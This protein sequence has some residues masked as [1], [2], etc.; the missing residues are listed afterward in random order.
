[1][2]RPQLAT[3]EQ[4]FDALERRIDDAG[5]FDLDLVRYTEV[6][7]QQLDAAKA[8]FPFMQSVTR[9]EYSIYRSTKDYLERRAT[10]DVYQMDDGSPA[11][12]SKDFWAA[13]YDYDP[14]A[15]A[16]PH[17]RKLIDLLKKGRLGNV[18]IDGH[19][20]EDNLRLTV[21]SQGLSRTKP[22]PVITPEEDNRLRPFYS[23][24][25]VMQEDAFGEWRKTG[26]VLVMDMDDR[27][28]RHRHP[29]LVLASQWPAE[30]C[31]D[32]EDDSGFHYV[33]E[34]V[35]RNAEAAAGVFPGDRNRTPI[36]SIQPHLPEGA[37]RSDLPVLKQLGED[38]NFAPYRY[39][40]AYPVKDKG[41][42]PD[43]AFVMDWYWDPVNEK[44]I[45]YYQDGTIYMCY[46]PSKKEYSYPC[47]ASLAASFIG[48]QSIFGEI[49]GVK[50]APEQVEPR[51][52]PLSERQGLP[53]GS[54]TSV[55]VLRRTMESSTAGF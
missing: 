52:I 17:S 46:D 35:Y 23:L 55:P 41:K 48:Q 45:C 43:I 30:D 37:S 20:S 1:M 24:G 39:V 49:L 50:D 19:P 26:H 28:I 33:S 40:S 29:W 5:G 22:H 34:V 32:T 42:G 44:E 8:R 27:S 7:D 12:T 51:F 47:F 36:C 10:N 14:Y 15:N 6:L 21:I 9:K 53:G 3:K 11:P 31:E 2:S 4:V 38:F 25:F 13:A 54:T 18:V 16:L